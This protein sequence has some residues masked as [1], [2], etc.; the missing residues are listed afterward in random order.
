MNLMLFFLRCLLP[1]SL[2][3][4]VRGHF[5][6][7]YCGGRKTGKNRQERPRK[8]MSIHQSVLWFLLL[9]SYAFST[10]EQ[11]ANANSMLLKQN[12]C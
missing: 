9:V 7:Q 4:Q 10:P 2:P 11:I 8:R 5:L 12:F 1:D 3:T 6:V